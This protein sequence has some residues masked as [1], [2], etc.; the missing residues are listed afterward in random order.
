ML[1]LAGYLYSIYLSSIHILVVSWCLCV[2]LWVCS[3]HLIGRTTQGLAHPALQSGAATGVERAI[4][5]LGSAS[6]SGPRVQATPGGALARVPN[7]RLRSYPCP[8]WVFLRNLVYI[9][10]KW[11]VG[12]G[13]TTPNG[14]DNSGFPRGKPIK[15]ETISGCQDGTTPDLYEVPPVGNVFAPAQGLGHP[16]PQ[17]GAYTKA[18]VV[19][20]GACVHT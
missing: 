5:V 19:W 18:E 6:G 8:L 12:Q 20:V 7:Q 13:A 14:G 9:S 11:Q 4:S 2:R 17:S 1:L 3:A 16:A 10:Q 15:K